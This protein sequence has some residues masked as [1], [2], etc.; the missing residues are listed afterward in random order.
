MGV[1]H[2]KKVFAKYFSQIL[3]G[4]KTYE[5]RLADWECNEGDV[6]EL[7]EIDDETKQPT[8][9]TVSKE[10]GTVIRT[11]DIEKLHWWPVED[12]KEYGF[13]VISLVE[14]DESRK[15]D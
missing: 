7:I 10:I 8:G 5:I 12:V 2:T 15:V 3:S 14:K 4:K 11:K 13:Q 6:L 1:V 9:R